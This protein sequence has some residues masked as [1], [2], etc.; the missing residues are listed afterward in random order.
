A[1][2]APDRVVAA[3]EGPLAGD[4][5]GV[6]RFPT[7][8]GGASGPA[9]SYRPGPGLDISDLAATGD[10]RLLVVE[11]AYTPGAG[12]TVH[13]ALAE[14]RGDTLARTPLADLGACPDLGAPTQQAQ[15]NPLLD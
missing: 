7:W 2:L 5:L 9:Y 13:L 4:D 12:N 8:T 11:R 14:P 10:G 3:M 15:A 1:V 6:R